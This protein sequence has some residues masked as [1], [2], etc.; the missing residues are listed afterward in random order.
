MVSVF[1]WRQKRC[2]M[3]H[4]TCCQ[5]VFSLHSSHF[6][7]LLQVVYWHPLHSRPLPEKPCMDWRLSS[8][9]LI[10]HICY[11]YSDCCWALQTLSDCLILM[12]TTQVTQPVQCC[13][14]PAFSEPAKQWIS[15][16]CSRLL[17]ESSVHKHEH[18]GVFITTILLTWGGGEESKGY[19]GVSS[20]H[21]QSS[22]INKLYEEAYREQRWLSV[23]IP[24]YDPWPIRGGA[25]LCS[26][27]HPSVSSQTSVSAQQAARH[28]SADRIVCLLVT[29]RIN[30]LVCQNP[31]TV[32]GG[33][34]WPAQTSGWSDEH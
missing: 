8:L 25:A 34:T 14:W 17:P 31:W 24:C 4:R 33:S 16:L 6:S 29:Y 27:A 9:L 32:G 13:L 19:I 20:G 1:S 5:V 10:W 28:H 26:E 15:Q 18:V 12:F 7:R 2:V 22:C 30:S 21:R 3:C 23:I 11:Y